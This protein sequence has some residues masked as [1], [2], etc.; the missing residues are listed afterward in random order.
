MQK[1]ITVGRDASCNIHV[2][3]DTAGRVSRHHATLYIDGQR[4]ILDDHST[5]GTK[6]N[7]KL[8]HHSR[9]EIREGDDIL[10]GNS[11]RL[12]WNEINR[13]IPKQNEFSKY[14]PTIPKQNEFDNYQ[15]TIAS[16]QNGLKKYWPAIAVGATVVLLIALV[17][18]LKNIQGND[19][20]RPNQDNACYLY[21]SGN[22]SWSGNCLDGYAHGTGVITWSSGK[23]YE[24]EVNKGFITGN[25]KEY[26]N[27]QLTFEGEFWDG[28]WKNGTFYVDGYAK[29]TGE[30]SN[31]KANGYGTLFHPRSQEIARKGF[32][33]DDRFQDEDEALEFCRQVANTIVDNVFWGGDN[34]KPVLRTYIKDRDRTRCEVIFDLS[35][36][37]DWE[38]SNF[39]QCRVKACYP[40]VPAYEFIDEYSNDNV[41]TWTSRWPPLDLVE[42]IASLAI[43]IIGFL[44]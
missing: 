28:K 13:F 33:T 9:G 22:Y 5:N 16:K 11:A 38:S 37:G 44:N 32:F 21:T 25:G 40:G 8:F 19:G 27:D 29:Y 39:Y 1:K 3:N 15:P 24:G 6:V 2:K 23:K 26:V 41:K 18:V 17:L 7:G 30:F 42:G 36:N 20:P 14:R 4:I 43:N 12:S 34:R 10:L 35:F 31:N